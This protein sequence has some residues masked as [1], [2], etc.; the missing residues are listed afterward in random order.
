[1]ATPEGSRRECLTIRAMDPDGGECEVHLSYERI[2]AV[3]QRSMGQAME[4]ARIV[5]AVLQNPT[6]VFTGLRRDEDEDRR[7][8]GWRC[9]CGVP[10]HSYHQD[11]TRAGPR[12]GQVHLVF[13][14]HEGV[15]YNWRWEPAN[16][17][18]PELPRDCDETRFRRRLL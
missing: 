13:V 18:D 15:A 16:P 14:N 7:G 17:D 4:C 11:G 9:Y 1:M 2:R 3:G 8:V 6:A 5:P 12:R 10:D